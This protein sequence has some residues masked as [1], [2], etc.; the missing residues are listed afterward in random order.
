MTNLLLLTSVLCFS[1]CAQILLKIGAEKQTL[2]IAEGGVWSLL[3][4]YLTNPWIVLAVLMYGLTTAL[5]IYTLGRVELSLFALFQSLSYVIIIG[6]SYFVL[7]ED[8]SSVR[9][10]GMIFIVIGVYLSQK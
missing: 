9:A 3:Y 1:S 6:F 8:V 10:V 7:A 4:S 2:H 5:T